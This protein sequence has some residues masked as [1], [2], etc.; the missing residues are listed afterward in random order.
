MTKVFQERN[1]LEAVC[2]KNVKLWFAVLV[3][4]KYT[5]VCSHELSFI[6]FKLSVHCTVFFAGETFHMQYCVQNILH[7]FVIPHSCMIELFFSQVVSDYYIFDQRMVPSRSS[8]PST[9]I[10]KR[11]LAE[12]EVRFLCTVYGPSMNNVT[13]SYYIHYHIQVE[14]YLSI[15]CTQKCSLKVHGVRKMYI[16]IYA[17][18]LN[19]L[20]S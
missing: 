1:L 20:V 4:H 15:T 10:L 17:M 12:P 3:V 13:Y 18:I 5:H 14:Y 19:S 2:V 6:N 7:S 8:T 16:I 11:L 9:H